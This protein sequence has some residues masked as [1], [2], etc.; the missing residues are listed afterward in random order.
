MKQFKTIET[1]TYVEEN[2]KVETMTTTTLHTIRT[3]EEL[4]TEEKEKEIEARQQSIYQLYQED[5]Y[6]SFLC[7]L[8]YI[9]EKYKNIDFENV[10]VDSNS[11]GNWIDSV[12]GFRYCGDSINVYGEWIEIEDIDLHIRKYIDSYDININDYYIDSDLLEKIQKTKKYKKWI[13]SIEKD[14]N[15]W[16]NDVNEACKYIMSREYYCPYNLENEEDREYLD[17]Y[18]CEEEFETTEVIENE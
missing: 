4:T 7:D 10:Y 12:K 14:V 5:L 11:Q 9:R 1:T 17:N 16:I 8:D 18:F 3:W 13:E 15:N 2:M 6:N